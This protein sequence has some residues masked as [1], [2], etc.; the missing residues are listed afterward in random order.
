MKI[1][2]ISRVRNEQEVIKNTLDHVSKLVD[3]VVIYD[4]CSTDNTVSICKQHESVLKVLEGKAWDATAGGRNKA[5]GT[6]R[7]KAYLE[8]VSLGADW[9]Y[10]FDADEYVEFTNVD[11]SV[12]GS[13]FFR[14]FDFYITEEDKDKAYLEREWMGCEYRDIP[15][16]FK[17]S[18]D[19]LFRQ[20]IPNGRHKPA[21]FG[22]Y[23][24]HYGK[25]ISIEEWEK[26]C[27]YYSEVRWKGKNK[28]LQ[29]RWEDRKGKAIH[30]VSDFG[31]PLIRWE[32]RSDK[33]KI[34]KL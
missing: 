17:V 25:A 31:R 32:D 11:L 22:G 4:D 16:L 10:N 19:I 26:D 33:S 3:G 13:Y 34:V 30:T 15:M 14:L 1:I 7:Q 24:R 27:V 6:L 12:S 8:A 21:T 5:E 20:R 2:G 29:K 23:V 28:Q 9:V 18:P